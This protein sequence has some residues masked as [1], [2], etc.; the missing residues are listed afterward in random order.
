LLLWARPSHRQPLPYDP[1]PPFCSSLCL[2][3]QISPLHDC[4]FVAPPPL[5]QRLWQL[6]LRPTAFA[7]AA[8]RFGAAKTSNSSHWVR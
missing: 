8:V 3:L 6:P 7:R 1:T 2:P 4:E 5:H